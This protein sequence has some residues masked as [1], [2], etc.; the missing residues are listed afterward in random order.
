M[1]IHSSILTRSHRLILHGWKHFAV[2]HARDSGTEFQRI[3][4][5]PFDRPVFF[6]GLRP[7]LCASHR[8]DP[9]VVVRLT[10]LPEDDVR[11][12][13]APCADIAPPVYPRFPVPILYRALPTARAEFTQT[14]RRRMTPTTSS[15]V[16]E[17]ST[18]D[19]RCARVHAAQC[20]T[21]TTPRGTWNQ[22]RWVD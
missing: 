15:D 13:V 4:D 8:T 2:R 11:A 21:T 12:V 16:L 1:S 6:A 5:H 3:G 17:P 18:T 10:A 20:V 14:T 9:E 19:A 22:G 7:T